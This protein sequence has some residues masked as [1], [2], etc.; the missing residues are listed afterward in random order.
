MNDT[1]KIVFL[2]DVYF[3]LNKY[4][5]PFNA[6]AQEELESSALDVEFNEFEEK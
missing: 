5:V 3:I 1:Q 4:Q 6:N 2:D